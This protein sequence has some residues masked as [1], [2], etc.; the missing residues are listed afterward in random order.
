MNMISSRINFWF[1]ISL[2][3]SILVALPILT[4]F[5]SFFS[6]TSEYYELLKN[7][8][9]IK[10]I[11][12]SVIILTGVLSLTFQEK[13]QLLFLNLVLGD[14]CMVMDLIFLMS[15]IMLNYHR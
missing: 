1:I 13:H 8:F 9:L 6:T 7:T 10:Y 12:N 3:I 4:V 11:S 5:A 2:T 14:T 15:C